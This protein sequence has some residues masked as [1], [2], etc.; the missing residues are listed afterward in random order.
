[1]KVLIATECRYF[2]E[3]DGVFY[4]QG[5][6]NHRFL[7]RYSEVF[8]E[9]V[10]VA[11]FSNNSSKFDARERVYADGDKISLVPLPD[12]SG[13]WE[14]LRE[15]F[16]VRARIRDAVRSADA[17][18]LRVPGQIGT[19]AWKELRKE[20]R[21][22]CLEV[23]GDPWDVFSPASFRSFARPLMRRISVYNLRAQCKE[24]LG[25]AYVTK[26]ALQLH[27]PAGGWTTHYSSV[28]LPS[29]AF[30]TAQQLRERM[31]RVENFTKNRFRPWRLVFVGGM[32]QLYKAPHVILKAA[33]ISIKKGMD[34]E[35]IM[36]GDGRYRS[37]LEKQAHQLGV[38][39]S[40]HFLGR[41]P[42]GAPVREQLDNAELFVLPS[43][44]E[45]LPRAMIEAMA[46]GL[47][48]I[49][50]AVGG[51]PELLE[52]NDM[53]PPGDITALA[54]K[55]CEILVDTKRMIRMSAQ[56]QVKAKEYCEGVLRGRRIAF[57]EH[58][59]KET[60]GWLK[61]KN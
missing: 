28:Y 49:G 27:Y 58:L 7:K 55:I 34:L 51:I 4:A 10:L 60:E 5:A 52:K 19:L 13:L 57:Y 1:M 39:E 24:A 44:T 26:S 48:C 22:F 9:V 25:V 8:E 6:V 29:E 41:L 21:P 11:R 37:Q 35:V 59:K 50:S 16:K 33:A 18:I 45:G 3:A 47:P 61:R 31:V 12:Y 15:S 53:V 40:V 43:R 17:A 2:R 38:A 30:I 23:V 46:R 42:A 54:D 14:Y 32:N 36:I 56:N 20:S